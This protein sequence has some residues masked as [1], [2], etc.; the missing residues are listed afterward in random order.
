MHGVLP[1]WEWQRNKGSMFMLEPKEGL[2]TFRAEG[3]NMPGSLY[4]SRKIHWPGSIVE[5]SKNASG[6]TI[7][8]GYDLGS[9]SKSSVL[10]DLLRAGLGRGQ[11]EKIAEG[12]G[13]RHCSAGIFVRDKR[14]EIGGITE[15]QQLR[16]FELS[17]IDIK[18]K[19]QSFYN[20]HRS[21]DAVRWD[22]LNFVLRD[23]LVDLRYQGL[24]NTAVLRGF[25]NNS[26]ES[27]I[28]S[29]RKSLLI[30]GYE[31]QRRRISYLMALSK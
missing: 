24:L 27:A 23:V 16:L 18:Q 4:Y 1:L 3:N 6:V 26:I 22:D 14:D 2:L 20:M 5:C 10:S 28:N 11:A 31:K 25:E 12:A 8:R 29:I 21:A 17:Y 7:G 13:K 15:I 30:M 9:R 19:T